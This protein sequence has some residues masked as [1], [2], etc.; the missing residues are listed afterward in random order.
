[1]TKN[2]RFTRQ[3]IDPEAGLIS[4][5]EGCSVTVIPGKAVVIK[6]GLR[7]IGYYD[8]WNDPEKLRYIRDEFIRVMRDPRNAPDPDW[9]I[10]EA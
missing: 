1:M 2:R 3:T 8:R 7:I 4:L 9:S 5:N 10:L 6:Q